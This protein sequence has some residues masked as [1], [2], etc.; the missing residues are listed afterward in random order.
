MNSSYNTNNTHKISTI[1]FMN[2]AIKPTTNDHPI[3]AANSTL[4]R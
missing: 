3:C 1:G 2:K 4:C